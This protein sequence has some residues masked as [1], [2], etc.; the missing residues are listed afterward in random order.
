MIA[1]TLLHRVTGPARN[2][3]ELGPSPGGEGRARRRHRRGRPDGVVE[4]IEDPRQRFCLGV[5]GTRN[6][7]SRIPGDA[8]IFAALIEAASA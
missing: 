2:G 5:H 7:R 6:T 1:G 4:G 8:K 3:S